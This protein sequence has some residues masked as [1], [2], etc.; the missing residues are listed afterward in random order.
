MYSISIREWAL[1]WF[2]GKYDGFQRSY[3]PRKVAWLWDTKRNIYETNR[4]VQRPF[5]SLLR[6]TVLC[7]VALTIYEALSSMNRE[8]CRGICTASV[9]THMYKTLLDF[10][11]ML[12]DCFIANKYKQRH[13]L[14]FISIIFK[15][16][17]N[18]VLK[19]G[20]LYLWSPVNKFTDPNPF[21]L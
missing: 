11:D 8:K 5:P 15:L 12:L 3:L 17:S 13:N 18:T 10:I 21:E 6:I 4:P 1:E 9:Y 20:D 19:F 2:D 14:S 16:F 7:S